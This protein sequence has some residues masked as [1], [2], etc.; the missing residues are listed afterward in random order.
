MRTAVVWGWWL[1]EWEGCTVKIFK[2]K[3]PILQGLP[4]YRRVGGRRR[5][6]GGD[7]RG[8]GAVEGLK[9]EMMIIP[10]LHRQVLE[11]DAAQPTMAA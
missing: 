11:E 5:G 10:K 1:V 2:K 9:R 8:R 7:G 3:L 4:G 6:E